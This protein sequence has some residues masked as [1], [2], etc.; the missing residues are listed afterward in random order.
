VLRAADVLVLTVPGT[1]ETHG[2]FT[3]LRAAFWKQHVAKFMTELEE[4]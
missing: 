1:A 4:R 3:H 2:H